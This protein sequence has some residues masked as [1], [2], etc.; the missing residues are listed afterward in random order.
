MATC[1]TTSDAIVILKCHHR[2]MSHL[3]VFRNFWEPILQYENVVF[4]GEQ[5]KGS[6][7]FV[8]RG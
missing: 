1:Q 8:R 6:I 5:E 7:T 3:N 4:N 2:D